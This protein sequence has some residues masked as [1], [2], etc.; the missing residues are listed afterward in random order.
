MDDGGVRVCFP[1]GK[2]GGYSC[3]QDCHGN[4][5]GDAKV[6]ACGCNDPDSCN[7]ACGVPNGDDSTCSDACGVPNG[8][9]STCSD[10]AGVPNG[11]AFTLPF[12]R[13]CVQ[14]CKVEVGDGYCRDSTGSNP[15]KSGATLRTYDSEQ[16]CFDNMIANR[17][18]PA[19]IA[20][21]AGSGKC[22]HYAEVAGASVTQ[23]KVSGAKV[24]VECQ[25]PSWGS[26]PTP[27]VSGW[28]RK[29]GGGQNGYAYHP[30]AAQSCN[31]MWG[32]PGGG[33]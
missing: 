13:A 30:G 32:T 23:T 12:T 1:D 2:P 14:H 28:T 27:G 29:E 7:D 20:F 9:D 33:A 11:G 8:D 22:Y 18:H 10:C 17:V 31:Q 4:W 5:G 15:W 25:Q 26:S 19:G 16:A 24:V 21:D 6:L 3:V